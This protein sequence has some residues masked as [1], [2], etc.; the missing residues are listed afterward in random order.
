MIS[1]SFKK[2]CDL[3]NVLESV[4]PIAMFREQVCIGNCQNY[5]CI[6][7]SLLYFVCVCIVRCKSV[8]ATVG[9]S[10][11]QEHWSSISLLSAFLHIL[12][13]C[14]FF[15]VHIHCLC[16]DSLPPSTPDV[17]HKI[18]CRISEL[19]TRSSLLSQSIKYMTVTSISE[20]ATRKPLS[21]LS[22]LLV[23]HIFDSLPFK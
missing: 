7:L 10:P 19:A 8:A 6:Y 2:V 16:S 5:K 4:V 14:I 13:L 15:Y 11:I 12:F 20:L 23:N 3:G 9:F 17:V 18:K 22:I 1:F 21:F